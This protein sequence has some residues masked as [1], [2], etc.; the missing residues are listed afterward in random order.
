MSRFSSLIVLLVILLFGAAGAR[1]QSHPSQLPALTPEAFFPRCSAR[2]LATVGFPDHKHSFLWPDWETLVDADGRTYGPG[3]FCQHRQVIPRP[4]LI[5]SADTKGIGP[6]VIKH[7]PGYSDCDM[8]QFLELLD[9]AGH[10]V[11][12]LLG[13]SLP[14]SLI[15]TNP[16]NLEAYSAQTGFGMWRLYD[17]AGDQV[18]MEPWPI[19]QG[20]TL[21][22]H[23]AFMLVTDWTLRSHVGS[24]LPPWLQ[25]GLVEYVGEDGQHLVNYMAQ[26]RADGDVLMTP[27]LV[28]ALLSKGPDPELMLDREIFR[29]ACYSAFLM[30]WELVENRGG[31]EALQDCLH[32]VAEGTG[33]S[34]ASV[35]VYGLDAKELA[36]SLDPIQLGEPGG[37]NPPL[38]VT[39][40]QP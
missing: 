21:D 28:D 8:L 34:D 15:V 26:F 25:Q 18:I 29:K 37:K 4:D 17:L 1:A 32:L 20:R 36:S 11:P 39:H 19:L 13:L 27:L 12:P 22:A 24:A 14:D 3:S 23:A 10:E 6:F 38:A 31:L 40:K 33:F 9:W 2:E 5:I 35:A 30:A 7:N 16:D